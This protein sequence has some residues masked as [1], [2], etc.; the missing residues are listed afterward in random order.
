MGTRCG[1]DYTG[2]EAVARLSGIELTPDLFSKLQT[3]E[4]EIINV[5]RD[6]HAAANRH[7]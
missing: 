2:V 7:P 4:S 5:D 6:K 3:I 1:L